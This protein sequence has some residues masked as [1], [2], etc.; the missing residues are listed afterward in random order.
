MDIER[1]RATELDVQRKWKGEGRVE[2]RNEQR[3][4]RTVSRNG[5]QKLRSNFPKLE[6]ILAGR[7]IV[8][9]LFVWLFIR[10]NMHIHMYLVMRLGY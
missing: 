10:T 7:L 8:S 1:T 3:N 9:T 4:V 5:K 2:D 6:R